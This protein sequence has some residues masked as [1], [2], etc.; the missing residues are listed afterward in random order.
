MPTPMGSGIPRVRPVGGAVRAS[1]PGLKPAE[2]DLEI[3][4]HRASKSHCDLLRGVV[5][6]F[7]HRV[8]GWFTFLRGRCAKSALPCGVRSRPP[9]RGTWRFA[10]RWSQVDRFGR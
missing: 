4:G 10:G 8:G 6:L 5:M 3:E 7:A 1:E 9:P 2:R